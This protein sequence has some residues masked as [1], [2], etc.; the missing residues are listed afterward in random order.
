M[1]IKL[2]SLL[3]DRLE[4]GCAKT[5]EVQMT[6][7][8]ATPFPYS[9]TIKY[10]VTDNRRMRY[11]VVYAPCTFTNQAT[12][13]YYCLVSTG[14]GWFYSH[15]FRFPVLF[16]KQFS[17]LCCELNMFIVMHEGTLLYTNIDFLVQLVELL[18]NQ[19][20]PLNHPN[21]IRSRDM[22]GVVVKWLIGILVIAWGG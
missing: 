22:M 21:D 4:I 6:Q 17:Q 20:I 9:R 15:E 19:H 14:R 12:T 7:I 13:Y 18:R 2:V 16:D 5:L 11:S 10:E 8:N 1:E 3:W